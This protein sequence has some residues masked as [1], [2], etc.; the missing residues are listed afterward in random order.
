MP[1][2]ECLGG[3]AGRVTDV[4]DG[5]QRKGERHDFF[6][7]Y[8]VSLLITA[9]SNLFFWFRKDRL[10]AGG[11]SEEQI[12]ELSGWAHGSSWTE[13]AAA[14]TETMD[15]QLL[16]EMEQWLTGPSRIEDVSEFAV[17]RMQGLPFEGRAASEHPPF[18]YSLSRHYSFPPKTCWRNGTRWCLTSRA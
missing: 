14:F 18:V 2:R 1:G 6:E 4:P 15:G 7:Y 13:R 5:G 3:V 16:S 12:E 10:L 11:F 8:V 17:T 9:D